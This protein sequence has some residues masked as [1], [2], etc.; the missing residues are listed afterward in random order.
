M[1]NLTFDQSLALSLYQ[2]DEQFPIDLDNAWQWL[3]Y[4]RKDKCLEAINSRLDKEIDF[5]TIRGKSTGGR[6]KQDIRLSIE[7]FKLLGM[8]AG[9]EQGKAI[10]KY[11]LECERIAK[12]LAIQ[13]SQS[14]LPSE[15][16]KARLA[17]L[18][19]RVESIRQKISTTEKVLAELR[20]EL[21]VAIRD[22]A[23]EAKA[24]TSAYAEV[25]EE[26]IRCT[27]VLSRAKAL[28]PYLNVGNTKCRK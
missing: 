15:A 18:H 7:G 6:P 2:S 21:L 5:S 9:T 10:R 28:N 16:H 19:S 26:Y 27:E 12:T 3:G 4:S 1:A 22:E 20:T 23:N 25:G 8:M 13:K 14:L 17:E 24:F 11:F